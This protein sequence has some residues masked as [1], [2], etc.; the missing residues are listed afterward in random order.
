MTDNNSDA[1]AQAIEQ[2]IADDVL[3]HRFK[4][5]AGEK[6]QSL[7]L[8]LQTNKLLDVYEQAIEDKKANRPVPVD[9]HKKIFKFFV[10]EE[11]WYKVLGLDKIDFRPMGQ[12]QSKGSS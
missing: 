2:V 6:A 12:H 5:A 1:L 4:R 9:K 8:K 3:F 10:D 11:Q 7:D